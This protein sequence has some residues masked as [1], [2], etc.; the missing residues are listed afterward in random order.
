MK[1]EGVFNET[2]YTKMWEIL[3]ITRAHKVLVE[4]V[5]L[6]GLTL[7][8]DGEEKHQEQVENPSLSCV[9]VDNGFQGCNLR[10]RKYP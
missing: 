3:I 2:I 7:T 8:G 9:H 6:W 10:P 4:N 1:D 5:N